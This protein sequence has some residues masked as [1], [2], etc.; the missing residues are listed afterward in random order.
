M[1]PSNTHS[2][3]WVTYLKQQVAEDLRAYEAVVLAEKDHSSLVSNPKKTADIECR[4]FF[5]NVVEDLLLKRGKPKDA[6]VRRLLEYCYAVKQMKN[7]TVSE[8]SH[9]FVNTQIDRLF[10]GIHR[11]PSSE[12]T[13]L[14][15]VY[16]IKLKPEISQQ[17]EL[18]R[19]SQQRL[20]KV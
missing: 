8:F 14:L 11:M 19:I 12:E 10:L 4:L 15:Y 2:C 17:R 1:E 9:R 7:E 5:D 18:E 16:T 3:Y 20:W 6:Q 13:K